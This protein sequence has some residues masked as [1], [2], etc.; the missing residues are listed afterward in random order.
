MAFSQAPRMMN[1][2]LKRALTKSAVLVQTQSMSR[3]PVLTGNLRS[4]H[5]FNVSGAGIG[6][7]AEI[8]P[9]AN[10][11]I[12]VHEGTRFMKARPFLKKGAEDS[13]QTIERFFTEAVQNV[14]NRISRMV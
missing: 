7:Q 6:M 9:T 13:L 11:G 3:T 4:S 2:E 12:F 10:Y 14:F 5:K 1:D 8:S